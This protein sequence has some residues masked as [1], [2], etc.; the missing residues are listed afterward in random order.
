MATFDAETIP[1]CISCDNKE[2]T[3]TC[4]RCHV[5]YCLHYASKTDN[6][7][8]ANCISDF[9]LHETIMEKQVSHELADGTV[10]FSRKYQ[11]RHIKLMGNDWLFAA[12][13]IQDLTDAQI[14]ESIEYHKANVSLM[15]MERESRKLER[16]HKLA[17]I[18]VTMA[19]PKPKDK[20]ATKTKVK[21]KA[22][23]PD[24]IVAMLT[25][26]A[27]S[28]YTPEQLMAAVGGKK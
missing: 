27:S 24:D 12:G 26:L 20:A 18:K 1:V 10:T 28:G 4:L 15:L 14:E 5:N 19:A 23:S 11:A 21:E 25:K 6:R 17:G 7:F 16:F 22:V 2:Q 3:K 9:H 13:L 8:C